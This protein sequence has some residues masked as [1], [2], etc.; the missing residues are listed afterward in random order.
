MLTRWWHSFH[1]VHV[2]QNTE[3]AT[4]RISQLHLSGAARV[5]GFDRDGACVPALESGPAP[6]LPE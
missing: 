3:V 4:V 1:N 6:W 2:Y 5:T